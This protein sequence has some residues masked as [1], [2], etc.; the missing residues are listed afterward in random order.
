MNLVSY[1]SWITDEQIEQSK[2]FD[3]WHSDYSS[4][5]TWS[6]TNL[7]K[8][9]YHIKYLAEVMLEKKVW[10]GLP[11]DYIINDNH[12]VNDGNHRLRA[13]QYLKRKY[14]LEI[15]IPI[16]KKIRKK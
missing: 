3:G 13:V 6:H 10:I 16:N 4:N 14:N 9:A 5:P 8:N 1:L 15:D 2:L 12:K 11:I 7:N